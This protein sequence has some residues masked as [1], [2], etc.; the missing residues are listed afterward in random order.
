[1]LPRR[2]ASSVPFCDDN[3]VIG[4]H[5]F[6]FIQILISFFWKRQTRDFFPLLIVRQKW[7]TTHRNL[8]IG[9]L[10]LIQDANVVP[11]H[12]KIENIRNV[13]PSTDEKVRN[14]EVAYKNT[15]PKEKL[16]NY[17]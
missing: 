3:G 1:M 4:R 12:W 6:K 10:V 17:K 11:G 14:V 13:S 15:D 2:A 9:D 5:Q 8:E 7:H 16:S